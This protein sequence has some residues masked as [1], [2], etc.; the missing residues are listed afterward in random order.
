MEE[1]ILILIKGFCHPFFPFMWKLGSWLIFLVEKFFLEVKGSY[2]LLSQPSS[3]CWKHMASMGF[4]SCKIDEKA[5]LWSI[6]I[7]SRFFSPIS[8]LS[9]LSWIFIKQVYYNR[10]GLIVIHISANENGINL[11]VYFTGNWNVDKPPPTD[12]SLS[13]FSIQ[14]C[15][16][17][18]QDLSLS[19]L[20]VG[21]YLHISS[22]SI[23]RCYEGCGRWTYLFGN[24]CNY[25]N[26][27]CS[28]HHKIIFYHYSLFNNSY[29]IT[30]LMI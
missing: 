14:R 3:A 24:L 1:G 8:W 21:L 7:D 12:R 16:L 6:Y 23:H 13:E 28:W 17:G 22:A 9:F 10:E 4:R 11:G 30:C 2:Q 20:T 26:H 25:Q 29:K 18:I 27:F 15:K 19:Y 5:L